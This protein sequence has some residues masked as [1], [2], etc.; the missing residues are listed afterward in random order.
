MFLAT[1][2][3][4]SGFAAPAEFA[5][6]LLRAAQLGTGT[7]AKLV[8][9]LRQNADV[10]WD[11]SSRF[12][13]R[14]SGILIRTFYET[15]PLPLMSSLVSLDIASLETKLTVA[16]LAPSRLSTSTRLCCTVAMKLRFPC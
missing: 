5:S 6:R 7:N 12:V 10:L 2:H 11:I 8:T 1:P 3:K 13:E 15:E 9:S 16:S 14:A 4:G